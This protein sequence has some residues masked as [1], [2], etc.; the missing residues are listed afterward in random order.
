MEE[1]QSIRLVNMLT[2]PNSG[3]DKKVEITNNEVVV[4]D[5][6]VEDKRPEAVSATEETKTSDISAP[7]E[8][9]LM[10][11][12]K[13]NVARRYDLIR[14]IILLPVTFLALVV[15]TD[16][17]RFN[18]GFYLGFYFA[19]GVLIL[20]KLYVV[21]RAWLDS[22]PSVQKADLVHAEYERLKSMSPEKI[23]N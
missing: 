7:S 4:A 22:R 6:I 2:P 5:K 13:Q 3:E 17:F 19:W 16:G 10:Y 20:Y 21:I 9:L 14:H 23:R 11:L 18:S 15:I 12:A 8:D 1:N